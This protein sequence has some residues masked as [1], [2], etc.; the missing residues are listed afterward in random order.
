MNIKIWVDD[1]IEDNVGTTLF[2]EY[3]PIKKEKSLIRSVA[4]ICIDEDDCVDESTLW[5]GS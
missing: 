5:V 1:Y 3:K 4:G 2:D